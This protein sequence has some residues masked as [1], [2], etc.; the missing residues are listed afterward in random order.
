MPKKSRVIGLV[1]VTVLLVGCSYQQ[2]TKILPTEKIKLGQGELVVELAVTQQEQSKGLSDRSSLGKN[3]GMLFVFSK[4]GNYTFWMDKMNFPID[5][6]WLNN[7]EVVGIN[8]N[9]PPPLEPDARVQTVFPPQEIDLVL[10]TAA[11]WAKD[12][13]VKVGSKIEYLP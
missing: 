1:L 9:V 7:G 4:P 12:N 10:E 5:I 13:A 3:R 11:G 8:D 6:I 2:T